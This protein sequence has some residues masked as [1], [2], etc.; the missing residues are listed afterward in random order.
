MFSQL[1]FKNIREV[2]NYAD[3]NST[4]ARHGNLQREVSEQEMGIVRAGLLP[5]LNAFGSA[6]YAPIM[7][8]QVIPESAF[9]GQDGKFRKVQFGMPWN[10][11]SGLE[12]SVPIINLEKW[13]Q[14]EKA[15]L[16][17]I[18]TLWS[19]KAKLENLHIQLI[20]WYHQALVA[21][22]MIRLNQQNIEVVNELIRVLDERKRNGVLE[23]ADFNRSKNLQLNVQTAQEDYQR[24]WNQSLIN[25]RALLNVPG[26]IS[27][28]LKDSITAF[29]WPLQ[30]RDA[31]RIAHRPAWKESVSKTDVAKQSVIESRRAAFPKLSL[32]TRY[33]YNWQMDNT[34]NIHFDV[35]T[36]GVRIDYPLF[37]GG[38]IRQQRRKADLLLQSAYIN[39][40]QTVSVLIQQQHEWLNN[41]NTACGKKKILQAKVFSATDNLR[42]AHLNLIEGVIE[43]DAF[44]NIFSDYTRAQ[45][46][47]LENL[48]NGILYHFLLTTN[49]E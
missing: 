2:L 25:L 29:N 33:M 16:Q 17:S 43:F 28:E 6:E 46:E 34:Q 11:T 7:A 14:L 1:Q 10:F 36:I 48:T 3:K 44:N 39:Q 21:K 42:I 40:Q 19:Q 8:T 13:S 9:G 15:K 5:R 49:I 31:N 47:E 12:L 35:N 37:N 18:E 23:P 32:S 26:S 45:M 20:Q 41:Y 30:D 27:I 4:V 38:F 22:E 24:V